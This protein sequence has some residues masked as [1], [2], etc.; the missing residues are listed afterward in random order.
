MCDKDLIVWLNQ[1]VYIT[2]SRYLHFLSDLAFVMGLMKTFVKY[3]ISNMKHYIY[4]ILP[5]D[6]VIIGIIYNI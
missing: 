1:Y 5:F 4:K 6:L 3:N 2:Y